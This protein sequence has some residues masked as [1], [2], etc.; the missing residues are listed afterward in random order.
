MVVLFNR[1]FNEDACEIW[2]D[3]RF[4]CCGLKIGRE[5]GD[6]WLF[7]FSAKLQIVP[8]ILIP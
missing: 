8:A 6:L 5:E 4:E 3:N 7:F 1:V 2:S